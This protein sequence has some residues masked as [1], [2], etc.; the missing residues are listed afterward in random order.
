MEENGQAIGECVWESFTSGEGKD[1]IPSF[2]DK[3]HERL[4]KSR[5][6]SL[7]GPSM[8]PSPKRD[9]NKAKILNEV[10]EGIHIINVAF[11]SSSMNPVI[12]KSPIKAQGSDKHLA[13]LT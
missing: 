9:V 10:I 12:F 11:T 6:G 1:I 7:V 3:E 8:R 13:C 2:R 5:R 4:S